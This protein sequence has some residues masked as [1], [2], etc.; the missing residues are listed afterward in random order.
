[1][2]MPS[3]WRSSSRARSNSATDLD[4]GAL[5]VRGTLGRVEGKLVI[6]EPKTDRSRRTVPIAAPLVVMLREHRL[7]QQTERQ[8]ARDQWIDKGLVFATEVGTEV[9]PRNVLRTIE[10]AAQKAGI[11]DVGVQTLRHSAAVAWMESGVHIK[12]VADLLGHSSISVTGD[13]YG[14]TSDTTARAAVDGLA[15]QLGLTDL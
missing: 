8:T 15:D 11:A 2:A 13:V 4:G 14:H 7:I 3:R 1:M 5:V 6:S 10:I 9:D 12:A